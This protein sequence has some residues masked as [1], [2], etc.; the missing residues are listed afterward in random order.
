MDVDPKY[1]HAYTLSV[2]FSLSLSLS[3]FGS[4]FFVYLVT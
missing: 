2:S 4:P 1:R 3:F